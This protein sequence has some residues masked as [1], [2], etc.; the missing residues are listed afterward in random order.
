MK[1]NILSTKIPKGQLKNR[2]KDIRICPR[3]YRG[4]WFKDGCPLHTIV[5]NKKKEKFED[6]IV[7]VR[8]IIKIKVKE[9][10]V[11]KEFL[12]CREFNII[13]RRRKRKVKTLISQYMICKICGVY[14]YKDQKGRQ[15]DMY[16]STF[17]YLRMRGSYYDVDG[18]HL[19]S[20]EDTQKQLDSKN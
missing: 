19:L 1:L 17:C 6:V 10:V 12:R 13:K 15:S 20:I 3:C 16:C 8:K 5:Y 14:K 2:I 18:L 4:F 9:G 7:K 11:I